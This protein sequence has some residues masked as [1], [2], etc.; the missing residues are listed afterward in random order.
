MMSWTGRPYSFCAGDKL[1]LQEGVFLCCS[2]A[3]QNLSWL[4]DYPFHDMRMILFMDFTVASTFP[5]LCG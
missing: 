2:S 4:S 3:R 5:L 1:S